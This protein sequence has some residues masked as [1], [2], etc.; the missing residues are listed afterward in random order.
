MTNTWPL[1]YLVIE[2][3]QT[4][5][6]TEEQFHEIMRKQDHDVSGPF[7]TEDDE[8]RTEYTARRR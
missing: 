4:Q 1:T 8:E 6:V 2:N 3:G 5:E 7:I